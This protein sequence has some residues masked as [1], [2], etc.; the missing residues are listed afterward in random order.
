MLK[1]LHLR[2]CLLHG[3]LFITSD[4]QRQGRIYGLSNA[5]DTLG[6]ISVCH[7]YVSSIPK[8]A[9]QKFIFHSLA[10]HL[11]CEGP[12]WAHS[13]SYSTTNTGKSSIA[14]V[15]IT[16]LLAIYTRAYCIFFFTIKF[17][18]GKRTPSGLYTTHMGATLP[19]NAYGPNPLRLLDRGPEQCCGIDAETFRWLSTCMHMPEIQAMS[20]KPSIIVY[21]PVINFT[22]SCKIIS[23]STQ[24]VLPNGQSW[25]GQY[26]PLTFRTLVF[27]P[28]I[29]LP[30]GC[31]ISQILGQFHIDFSIF[32]CRKLQKR[33]IKV[34][35]I[36][37]LG[38]G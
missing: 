8:E 5:N 4:R 6:C 28:V 35:I 11:S 17:L 12:D 18:N 38:I 9:E 37:I 19:S 26:D 29:F 10:L 32:S 24:A 33:S 30:N 23:V 14:V 27:F 34:Q 31:P 21:Y 20:I 36:W 1:T 2:A 13:L 22:I 7:P 3:K 16:Q 25:Q 15:C